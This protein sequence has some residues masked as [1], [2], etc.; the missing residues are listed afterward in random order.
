MPVP[1]VPRSTGLPDRVVRRTSGR[2]D[3]DERPWLRVVTVTP[4]SESFV[5]LAKAR[6]PPHLS[7]RLILIW[8][9]SQPAEIHRRRLHLP[10]GLRNDR[11]CGA[12][13]SPN[14]V[15]CRAAESCVRGVRRETLADRR[16][17]F[18]G[19]HYDWFLH[20]AGV[21]WVTAPPE[22]RLW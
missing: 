7:C 5:S 8:C 15:R 17:I 2:R 12:R 16:L 19:G 14:K 9:Q 21:K 1:C 4:K 3:P 11:L 22:G 20:L 6:C 18:E 10:P 13:F